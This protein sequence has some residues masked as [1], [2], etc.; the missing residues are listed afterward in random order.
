MKHRYYI[1]K[2]VVICI[3]LLHKMLVQ[4]LMSLALHMMMVVE[5]TASTT[6]S[7][8]LQFLLVRFFYIS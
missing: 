3:A 6:M 8:P 1:Q 4:C 5:G 7:L 2:M